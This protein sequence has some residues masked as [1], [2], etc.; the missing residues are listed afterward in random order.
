MEFII[1]NAVG[2]EQFPLKYIGNLDIDLGDT[3]DFALEIPLAEYNPVV[4]EYGCQIFAP[5]TEYG[6]IITRKN[7]VDSETISLGGHTWRGWIANKIIEPP[8]GQAYRIVSGDANA[9]IRGLFADKLG[10]LFIVDSNN[11]GIQINNYQIPRYVTLLDG[12]EGMLSTVGARLRIYYAQGAS[13][14]TGRV[15]VCA[16]PVTDYSEDVEFNRDD[17]IKFDITEE[18]GGVNHL[19]CMGKGELTERLIVHLYVSKNGSIGNQKYY[20]GLQE[21]AEVFDYSSAEDEMSLVEYGIKRLRERMNYKECNA[22]VV[23]NLQLEIGDI[24][25]GRERIT[26]TV[27]KSPVVQKILKIESNRETIEYKVKGEN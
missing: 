6:G 19:V 25:G 7:P 12:I 17:K 10:E 20:T 5:N 1:T 27:L 26:N 15:H 11:S 8:Q 13:N 9:V 16:V 21:I 2:V 23:N 4:H 18:R 22:T 24:V 3:N 14:E